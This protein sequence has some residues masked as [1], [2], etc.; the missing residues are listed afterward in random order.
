VPSASCTGCHVDPHAGGPRA[1]ESLGTIRK[2]ALDDPAPE[3]AARP[4]DHPIAARDCASCHRET[5]FRAAQ[6][7]RGGFDHTAD[8]LFELRGAHASVACEG[9]HTE[10][11][12]KEER[13]SGVA[14]GRGAD[15]D[16]ATCHEDP[17]HGEMRAANG[18]RSCHS[19]AGWQKGFDHDRDTRFALDDLHA[20]LACESC[21]SDQRFR[22]KGRECQACHEDAAQLLAGRFGAARGEADP[23]AEA[24]KCADCHRPTR[25]ANRPA[26]L[27]QR[28]AECHTAEYAGLLATWTSKLDSLAGSTSLDA[29]LAERLR[30]SGAHNFALAH[31]LLREPKR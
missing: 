14:P 23:H 28:C 6:L 30:R 15:P 7:R 13:T 20:P 12:R 22:A 8:T 3:P 17:H 2:V 27:G 11:R 10:A 21:H 4:A 25:A 24:V 19:E 26:A 31:D 1:P 16:C 29:D 9:C 5:G 18:C